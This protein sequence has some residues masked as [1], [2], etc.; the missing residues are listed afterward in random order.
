MATCYRHP[1][2]ETGVACSNCSRPICPDCMTPT[3]VGMRCPECSQ[4]KTRVTRGPVRARSFSSSSGLSA[5]VV[6][7]AINVILFVGEMASGGEIGR[8]GGTLYQRLALFG[9]S[10][11]FNHEYYRMVTY[12][13]LH[14]GFLHIAFNMW[15]IWVIGNMLEPALGKVRF[16]ALYFASLLCGSFAVLL[17]EPNSVTVGASGAAFGLL[18]AAIVEARARGIDIWASG[19]AP[20]AVINFLFTFLFPGISIGGHLGGFVGGLL[21]GLIYQQ[22]D[23]ARL[24]QLAGTAGAVVLGAAAV[25]GGIVVAGG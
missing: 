22:A 3:P 19:L 23:R 14:S 13:F 5:T 12:G 2:R 20:I 21:V 4:E 11:E 25:V 7:I 18:G 9:P 24:P 17:L 10:I 1:T 6:L 15:F 8:A 16:V